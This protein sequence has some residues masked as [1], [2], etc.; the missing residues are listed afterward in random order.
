MAIENTIYCSPTTLRII[1]GTPSGKR[2]RV[3]DLIEAPLPEGAMINGIITDP[4]MLTGF[5]N[6]T[7]QALDSSQ[8][9]HL[10]SRQL[11]KNDTHI[12]IHSNSVQTR[13][14]E[15]PAVKASHVRAFVR[16]EFDQYETSTEGSDE[17][18]DYT[19][20]NENGAGGGVEILAC[21]VGRGLVETYLGCVQGAGFKVKSINIGVNCIIKLVDALKGL[22][23]Q[24]FLLA[25]NTN[26]EQNVALFIDGIYRLSNRYRLVSEAGSAAWYGELGNNIAS[27]L[28]FN[29]SQRGVSQAQMVY[30]AGLEP[31]QVQI[32]G[33]YSQSL[34]VR[35]VD[36]D[37]NQIIALHK[38]VA[39]AGSFSPNRYLFNL[40]SM[41]RR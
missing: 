21:A 13:I 7:L 17:L 10:S 14:L 23:N 29:R 22:A 26:S 1:A 38:R 11:L 40:G 39:Q 30:T 34:G 12:V 19:V 25:Y 3:E 5:L 28:Q 6:R 37:L 18:Y 8:G 32:L 2:I 24:T 36:F 15:V 20:L 35:I 41:V 33:G 4:G 31:E 16:Q 9:A 27:M